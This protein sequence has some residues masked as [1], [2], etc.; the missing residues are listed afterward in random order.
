MDHEYCFTRGCSFSGV[1]V[2]W[3]FLLLPQS[4]PS[5]GNN[6]KRCPRMWAHLSGST[7]YFPWALPSGNLLGVGDGFP[8][9]S[10][11]LVEHGYNV[12][13]SSVFGRQSLITSQQCSNLTPRIN[14]FVRLSVPKTHHTCFVHAIY[15]SNE[16]GSTGWGPMAQSQR[17][18]L[19]GLHKSLVVNT[20]GVKRKEHVC[21]TIFKKISRNLVTPMVISCLCTCACCTTRFHVLPHHILQA[22]AFQ[23]FLGT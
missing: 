10:L 18:G 11:I 4:I 5:S 20:S 13:R 1:L 6:S 2:G 21:R 19:G 22:L 8:N 17:P 12:R 7:R 9:T 23:T 3:Y 16:Q 14:L 15:D